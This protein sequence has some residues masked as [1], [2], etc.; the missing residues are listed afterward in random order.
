MSIQHDVRS[1]VAEP[2]QDR[3]GHAAIADSVHESYAFTCLGCGHGWEQS[4]EVH[5]SIDRH[6]ALLTWCTVDGHRVP[7]PLTRPV[8]PACT[9]TTVRILRS[10]TVAAAHAPA[11]ARHRRSPAPGWLAALARLLGASDTGW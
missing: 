9:G 6:G 11:A 4:Y 3:T 5:H 7:S 1:P 10:G 2:V 8:C